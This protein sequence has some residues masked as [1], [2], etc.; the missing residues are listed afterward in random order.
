[1][2]KRKKH[3]KSK[4]SRNNNA[5]KNTPTQPAEAKTQTAEAKTQT[6]EAASVRP[7]NDDTQPDT[8]ANELAATKPQ[9]KANKV[10]MS[11]VAYSLIL[12]GIIIAVFVVL[13]LLMSNRAISDSFYGIIKI[14]I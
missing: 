14:K 10:V 6:A 3:K 1:M 13:M 11:D 5:V 9:N 2:S 8:K 4:S 7:A 12:L